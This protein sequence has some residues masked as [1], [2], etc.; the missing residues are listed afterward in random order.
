MLIDRFNETHPDQRREFDPPSIKDSNNSFLFGDKKD[1]DDEKSLADLL[2]EMDE[3]IGLQSVKNVFTHWSIFR[4]FSRSV[5][6]AA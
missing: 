4:I 3:L 1:D 5:L 2:K 6:N